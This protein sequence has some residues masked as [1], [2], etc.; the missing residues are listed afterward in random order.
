MNN[1]AFRLTLYKTRNALVVPA[2][3][4]PWAALC[5]CVAA[6]LLATYI[7]MAARHIGVR[8]DIVSLKSEIKQLQEQNSV[9]EIA[10]AK[11]HTK[12]P[13][14][15]YFAEFGLIKAKNVSY[16]ETPSTA[17]VRAQNQ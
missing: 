3:T 5:M 1:I 15:E 16:I 17:L 8:H 9:L 12:E 6:A 4:S 11:A 10:L 2:R 14:D 13:T 7:G